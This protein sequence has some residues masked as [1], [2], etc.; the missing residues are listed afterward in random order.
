MST[1]TLRARV[2]GIPHI[3]SITE[4]NVRSGPGTN[5]QLI[6]RV[7]VGTAD[8][9]VME[10]A[11]DAERR[12]LNGKTYTWFRLTFPDGRFGWIRDDLVDLNGDGRRFGYPLLTTAVLAFNLTRQAAGVF[13]SSQPDTSSVT[14][15]TPVHPTTPTT[16]TTPTVSGPAMAMA[17]GATGVNAR[18]GPGVNHNPVSFRI[19]YREICEILDAREGDDGDV[20]KWARLRYQ[21]QEGWVREDILRLSGNFERFNLGFEDRYPSPVRNGHWQRDFNEN[22]NRGVIHH[23]WDHS[24]A[25]GEPMLG[26]PRGGYVVATKFCNRCGTAGA[27]TLE[28]GYTTLN[29]Q[30]VF[31]DP[32]WNYGYGHYVI[33]RYDHDILP[34]S[35]QR[36]LAQRGF[37]DHH[38][39][40]MYAH[41]HQI[42]VSDDTVIAPN[43]P[44]GQLG[45]SGNSS[46]PHLHL[47]VR[48]GAERAFTQWF[49]LRKGLMSPAILFLR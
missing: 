17:M 19:G 13:G 44:V 20:F 14:P 11:D 5:Q 40:V 35:T 41:L 29:D 24:G 32:G 28:R 36:E 3:P 49:R 7:P 37:R 18:P 2:V 10:V 8:L 45:N 23:G 47:E 1:D 12:G 48:A 9:T 42:L 34:A 26:G 25:V 31:S 15:V 6:F 16:P 38:L 33:V 27:S 21:G 46:G 39:F 30:R 43:Q 22:P 4:V